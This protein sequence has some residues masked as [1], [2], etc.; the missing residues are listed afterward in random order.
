MGEE[1]RK[2]RRR[3]L[4]YYLRVF[5]RRDGK[6]I[7]HLVDL[8]HEGL[9]LMS[10]APVPTGVEYQMRMDLPTDMFQRPT[11]EFDGKALW[12]RPDINPRFHDTG[13][14]LQGLSDVDQGLLKLLIDEVG[15]LD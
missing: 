5:D 11:V 14:K 2:T 10:E 1:K 15:F 4:I 9:M 6:L 13:F 3:H 8:T 12:S 7:G